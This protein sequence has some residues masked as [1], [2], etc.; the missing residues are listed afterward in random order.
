[1]LQGLVQI[2][3]GESAADLAGPLG[4]AQMAGEVAQIG[5]V[6]LL[7]FAA[8]LSLNLGLINLFPIPALDGGHFMTLV[9]EAVRGKPLSP[10]ALRYAQSVG[11]A[12][13]LTLMIFAT[14]ND[15]VRVFSGG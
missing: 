1:M 2:F 14:K 3:T 7:N 8:L 12:L 9:F 4:V 13:L 6:P 15:I 5:F 10:K 11:I